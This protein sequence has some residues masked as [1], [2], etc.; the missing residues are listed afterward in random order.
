MPAYVLSQDAEKDLREIA[1]YTLKKWGDV[2]FKKYKNGLSNKFKDIANH[3]VVE[4]EFS[5]TYP[6]LRV[7]KYRYHFI[8]YITEGVKNPV[9]I[10]VIHEQRDIVKKLTNRLE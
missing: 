9:I 10:G 2:A 1:Q 8:F 5:K 7:S 3:Q 4:R 6:Q